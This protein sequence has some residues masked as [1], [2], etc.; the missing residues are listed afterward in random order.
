[1][2]ATKPQPDLVNA[3]LARAHAEADDAV[4][5]GDTPWD[6]HAASSANVPTIAVRTGGFGAE[7]LREAGAVALFESV[8]D[9][10]AHLD[11]T[12]LR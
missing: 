10:I 2:E 6:V 12:A 11:D 4:L 9:L 3:A 5:V 8:A 1:M 7:E